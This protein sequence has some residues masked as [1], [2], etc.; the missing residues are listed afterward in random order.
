MDEIATVASGILG[1]LEIAIGRLRETSILY[2]RHEVESAYGIPEGFAVVV[3]LPATH[4]LIDREGMPIFARGSTPGHVG[5]DGPGSM[6]V[7]IVCGGVIV[8]PGDLIMGDEDGI[9]VLPRERAA[10]ILEK[11][12]QRR[13]DP[14]PPASRKVP[15]GERGFEEKLR[16]FDGIEWN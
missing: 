7:P 4:D 5:G 10:A 1:S 2:Q 6:N 8:N 9:V 15:Y 16:A 12:G 14:F 11:A 13:K 3:G